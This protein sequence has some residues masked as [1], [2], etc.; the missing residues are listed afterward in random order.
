MEMA[1]KRIEMKISNNLHRETHIKF[2]CGKCGKT[3]TIEEHTTVAFKLV[4]YPC[5]YLVSA[6]VERK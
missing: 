4:C 2:R 3:L 6:A 5:G 1:R